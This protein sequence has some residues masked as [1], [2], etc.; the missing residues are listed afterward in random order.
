MAQLIQRSLQNDNPGVD[1]LIH[2]VDPLERNTSRMMKIIE[3]L[4]TFSRQS[5]GQFTALDI[6]Q[7]IEDSFML[8]GE[9]LVLHNIE[10]KKK[11]SPNLPHI[12]G[13]ANQLEQVLLNLMTNSRDAI[14]T[15]RQMLENNARSGQSLEI[16]TRLANADAQFVDIL[17][18]DTGCG[19]EPENLE[20]IFDPF[21]TTKE[22][23]KGTGLGLSISYGIIKDHKGDI[24]AIETSPDGT[25]FRIRL[26]AK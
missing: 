25:T 10:V 8:M 15:K 6:N 3:H 14:E 16:I 2:L 26:P 12:H 11:L 17:F 9:Q 21:F 24:Q 7:V 5:K 23:G 20:K 19:F 22:A 1:E 4:R 13:D 18:T